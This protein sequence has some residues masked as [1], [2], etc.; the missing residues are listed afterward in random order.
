[1]AAQRRLRAI[2]AV[3]LVATAAAVLIA[4][5]TPQ[6]AAEARSA[7]ARVSKDDGTEINSNAG[8]D[9]L[10]GD[11]RYVAFV[12]SE[13]M[14]PDDTDPESLDVYVVDN[15][16]RS[17]TLISQF[18]PGAGQ[19][20][21]GDSDQPA[22]SADGRYIAF[23]TTTPYQIEDDGG[24]AQA[25]GSVGIWMV[26]RGPADSTGAFPEVFCD[27]SIGDPVCM[28]DPAPISLFQDPGNVNQDD[29]TAPIPETEMSASGR[30][31]SQPTI[32]GDGTQVAFT[33]LIP[34]G[35]VIACPALPCGSSQTRV[36]IRDLDRDRNGV[37]ALP[38]TIGDGTG[39]E[40]P[41][42]ALTLVVPLSSEAPPGTSQGMPSISEDGLHVAVVESISSSRAEV[43]VYDRT[44]DGQGSLDDPS[45]LRV[46]VVSDAFTTDPGDGRFA[47]L[48]DISGDGSRVT[49]TF[50]VVQPPPPTTTTTTAPTTTTTAPP[51]PDI[52][53]NFAPLVAAEDFVI[54]Q[55]VVV[56]RDSSGENFNEQVVS[57]NAFGGNGDDTSAFPVISADGRYIAFASSATNLG[58]DPGFCEEANS[59]PGFAAAAVQ[60]QAVAILAPSFNAGLCHIYAVDLD[61][62]PRTGPQLVSTD[63][64]GPADAPSTAPDISST[65]RFISF[66]SAATNLDGAEGAP[67]EQSLD[68]YLLEWT[69]ILRA[70][71]DPVVMLP[72]P[73]GGSTQGPTLVSI[74]TS[75]F[76]PFEIEALTLLGPHDEDFSFDALACSGVTFHAGDSCQFSVTFSPT[77]TGVREADILVTRSSALFASSGQ[78]EIELT[79]L[80]SVPT[81]NGVTERASLSAP[82]ANGNE[83]S[84]GFSF[85]PALSGNGRYVAFTTFE[86]LVPE[87]PGGADI[88]VRD[89]LRD[90]T[91]LI[92]I[93]V[94]SCSECGLVAGP[95]S[96]GSAG[97][98]AQFFPGSFE[99]SISGNGRYI[100][101]ETSSGQVL[102]ADRGAPDVAGDFTAPVVTTVVSIQPGSSDEPL[103]TDNSNPSISADGTQ[104]AFSC[105]GN[106]DNL[107]C[108][109]EEFRDSVLVRDLDTN[110]D[111]VIGGPTDARTFQ[112]RPPGPEEGPETDTVFSAAMSA[113]GN[114]V[115]FVAETGLSRPGF[116]S[117]DHDL[118]WV[119]DR[120][121]DGVGA[122]DDGVNNPAAYHI[123]TTGEFTD[124]AQDDG[125]RDNP[126]WDTESSEPAID[127]DGSTVSYTFEFESEGD[128]TPRSEL[129]ADISQV[130][131][132]ERATVN[133]AFTATEVV[134]LAGP[135]EQIGFFDPEDCLAP[136]T[137]T[138]NVPTTPAVVLPPDEDHCSN[139][140]DGDSEE[141][142]IS[143]DGRYVAFTTYARNLHIDS[144]C[145][146]FPSGGGV[147]IAPQPLSAAGNSQL[148]CEEGGEGTTFSDILVVDRLAPGNA[149]APQ[150]ASPV[151]GSP[152]G[153]YP[154]GSAFQP[155]V[156]TDGRFVAFGSSASN[157]LG[158]TPCGEGGQCSIDSNDTE[159]IF[160]REWDPF[161]FPSASDL[162]F[163]NTQL[164]LTSGSQSVQL[165]TFQFGPAPVLGIEKFGANPGDFTILGT[166]N[167]SPPLSTDPAAAVA[168]VPQYAIVHLDTPCTVTVAFAP[169][170]IGTRSASIRVATG[171]APHSFVG[172]QFHEVDL[173]AVGD[174]KPV[175]PEDGPDGPGPSLPDP[176]RPRPGPGPDPVNPVDPVDPVGTP[177]FSTDPGSLDFGEQLVTVTSPPQTVT[178]TNTG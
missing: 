91:T 135:L 20:G 80:A 31:P 152:E 88:Y 118:V 17:T 86:G 142:D 45:D 18:V 92:S 70:T 137:P 44:L 33:V 11:G 85:D 68:V 177:G 66:S 162:L 78:A 90:T 21:S 104:I 106:N 28:N 167:C 35:A 139:A 37:P 47:V 51:P 55:V 125:A 34:G 161:V 74:G 116:D 110:R 115:A 95:L 132:A 96:A 107:L 43:A 156:S 15:V 154:D 1:M 82:D 172:T 99:P 13:Q 40:A 62:E 2:V 147:T 170:A 165:R 53:V 111:G 176:V 164:G 149:G 89:L 134:S 32:S 160:V 102:L 50:F 98:P 52:I 9:A 71:Q 130:L 42:S 5:D 168:P 138:T 14:D 158:T 81:A 57:R 61:E 27:E 131:V 136:T 72:T 113:D 141:S 25:D 174:P 54:P 49:F 129:P 59:G 19:S 46:V 73:V 58:P 69:P 75:D 100:A 60:T 120:D 22:I 155:S 171:A 4:R 63:F 94:A 79:G 140:G 144:N 119:Y 101:Y 173:L 123:V 124:E 122:R 56:D 175:D 112:V 3:A 8:Q 83:Q 103:N 38:H 133:G 67:P 114:H 145:D 87:D 7:I 65:G 166:S 39:Q 16:T 169:S 93:P 6:A 23:R 97:A 143:D 29:P 30:I 105:D 127:G 64:G 151:F 126:L 24:N 41:D 178:V 157:L 84:E 128:D 163:P 121:L 117:L 36:F 153:V 148:T 77:A 76:G 146:D 150:L 159:D 26:D 12:T 109:P 108:A 48:P 10:S